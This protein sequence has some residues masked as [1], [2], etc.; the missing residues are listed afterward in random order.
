[1]SLLAARAV[2]QS[3]GPNSSPDLVRMSCCVAQ[4]RFKTRFLPASNSGT[5]RIRGLVVQ[6]E[7]APLPQGAT[8]GTASVSVSVIVR[9]I[10]TTEI[11]IEIVRVIA[12][13]H[14]RRPRQART[15]LIG[16][17]LSGS[18]AK[19][20]R[21]RRCDRIRQ[22][23]SGTPRRLSLRCTGAPNSGRRLKRPAGSRMA[24]AIGSYGSSVAAVLPPLP[25]VLTMMM[26]V[27]MQRYLC[28]S[29][30]C[31]REPETGNEQ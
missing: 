1:M 25:L 17:I 7:A 31:V 8:P 5:S 9:G 14:A 24:S 16:A 13:V 3:L 18:R 19:A 28:T 21:E 30:V 10:D 20:P 4:F 27:M 26:L 29:A 6:E 2:A 23:E 11:V 22:T 12:G 15:T